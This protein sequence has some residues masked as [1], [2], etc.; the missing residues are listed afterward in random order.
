MV[1]YAH[2]RSI[3]GTATATG[4]LTDDPVRPACRRIIELRR[5]SAARRG[6]GGSSHR[7]P[8]LRVAVMPGFARP[9]RLD[10]RSDPL[11]D[12]LLDES[13]ATPPPGRSPMAPCEPH[14]SW[15]ATDDRLLPV[16]LAGSLL[17]AAIPCCT[18]PSDCAPSAPRRA[19]G[20][21]AVACGGRSPCDPDDM[22]LAA[23]RRHAIT[24][25]V[26][27]GAGRRRRPRRDGRA[28]GRRR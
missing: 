11:G 9:V 21:S 13:T 15:P 28:Q 1:R 22:G 3:P 5:P 25:F 10:D 2:E 12:P 18:L 8:D 20:S 6:H 16:E 24:P 7:G 26:A 27:D 17:L 14:W 19:G 23:C 4:D